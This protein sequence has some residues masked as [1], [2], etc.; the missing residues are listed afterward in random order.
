MKVSRDFS[1]KLLLVALVV[2]TG[3]CL[4]NPLP[5][6]ATGPVGPGGVPGGVIVVDGDVS[7]EAWGRAGGRIVTYTVNNPAGFTSMTWGA[8]G[9]TPV[10]LAFDNSIDAPG[11]TLGL[12]NGLSNLPG[13]VAVWTGQATI[14]LSVGGPLILDTRFTLTVVDGSTNPIL[15]SVAGGNVPGINVLSP[16]GPFTATLLFEADHDGSN[17]LPSGWTPVLD[18]FDVLPTLSGTPPGTTGPVLTTFTS[19]FFFEEVTGPGIDDHDDNMFSQTNMIKDDISALDGKIEFLT[20]DAINRLVQLGVDHTAIH[21]WVNNN[22]VAVINAINQVLAS[23][24]EIP[25]FPND[26]ASSDDVDQA[27]QDLQDMLLILFGILPCPAEAGPLCDSA[28]FINDL[29]AKE[30]KVQ[31]VKVSGG[32]SPSWLLTTTV[33]GKLVDVDLN[34]VLAVTVNP[35]TNVV[36]VTAIAVPVPL[37]LGLL[38][39]S[40]SLPPKSRNAKAFQIDVSLDTDTSVQGSVLVGSNHSGDDD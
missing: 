3:M 24:P 18:L 28:T 20:I 12:D 23:I 1:P 22:H 14:P 34:K 9:A 39:V 10:Q 33:D 36:D 38:E 15:L 13:G 7:G 5:A 25:E 11:E 32:S 17:G 30:I 40:V 19:G 26:V 27:R 21:A 37:S 29:A 16:G 8:A 4:N 6:F 2:A 35:S 31:A